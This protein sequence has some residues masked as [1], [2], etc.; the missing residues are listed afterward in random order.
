M[1]DAPDSAPAKK[2]RIIHWD[3]EHGR[4]AG[5]RP[6]TALRI[7]AWSVG[8]LFGLILVAGLAV[9]G[10]RLVVG[11]QFLRP[12]G[13]VAAPAPESP[14]MAFV[15]ESKAELAHET[16]S[17]A[18][19]EL[20]RLPQD[21]PS[22]LEQLIGIEKDFLAGEAL[23]NAH[24][25]SQAYAH[26]VALNRDIDDYAL[27]VKLKQETQ[28]AYDEVIVRMKDLDRARSLAPK[29]FETAFSDAGIGQEFFK[30]GRFV[31]AKKQFD[32][33]FAALARA[34][35]ALKNYVNRNIA[36]GQQAVANGQRQAALLAFQAALE[37]DPG[38]EVIAQGMKRA[39]V[40]DRVYALL[41]Q[42]AAFE[43]KAD[44]GR[45][46]ES[47][48]KAFEIDAFSAVAQQGESRNERLEKEAEFKT[49]SDAAAAAR[50][51]KDWTKAISAYERA[52]QVYPQKDDIK[53]ALAEVRETAHL[54]AVKHSLTKAFDYE[55]KYEWEQAR[56]AYDATL[57]LDPQ[58]LEARE[59][60]ARTGKMIRTLM[61]F[62]K[63]VEVAEQRA[64]H[65]EFQVAIRSFNEA[66]AVKPAYLPLTDRVDQLRALLLAQSQ[67]V[68]VTFNSD[69]DSWVSISNFRM[70][71]KIRSETVKMLP[72]DY[73][74]VAR[75]KGYQDVLLM[76]QVRNGTTPPPVNV[77]CS[78]RT[79]R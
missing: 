31:R 21:H 25:F 14:G 38:N 27:N 6:W 67:P 68:P 29:E 3:P 79:S 11:P 69:G 23:L 45:A 59:G 36:V 71:G 65:A 72:G 10:V 46:R 60:Y 43:E 77:V 33:A 75:R 70:L 76:L 66:M 13:V 35:Q 9:R 37:K 26:F 8:G 7:L 61:Q 15:S 78:L 52:L 17:K 51:Q 57:Q 30:A 73:E 16:A 63:L 64:Q 49:A 44:Y 55:N 20:R 58:H 41:L 62:N 5:K 2:R 18:L 12:G 56:A 4:A 48:T 34:E 1:S 19:V 74:I 42:G 32:S 47:F 54:E 39:E 28:K 22:Q 24:D 50:A 40:A 53:K